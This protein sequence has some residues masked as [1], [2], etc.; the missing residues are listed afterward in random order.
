MF[1]KVEQ[2]L[3]RSAM[4]LWKYISSSSDILSRVLSMRSLKRSASLD[5]F[6]KGAVNYK[7]FKRAETVSVLEVAVVH[8]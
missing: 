7:T 4:S 2:A 6:F 8:S 1:L 3:S 5:L